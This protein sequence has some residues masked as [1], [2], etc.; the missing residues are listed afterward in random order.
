MSRT[1][2][3]IPLDVSLRKDAEKQALAQGFSSL[4][5][6]VRVFL[7]K[8]ANKMIGVEF[9][10][11]V[12]LSAKAEKRYMKITEDFKKGRNVYRAKSVDDL[13]KQLHK[14]LLS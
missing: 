10:S 5:E 7:S 6:A 14:G 13:M 8:L 2:L 1:V 12:K 4:Q 9:E 11:T 3:Q